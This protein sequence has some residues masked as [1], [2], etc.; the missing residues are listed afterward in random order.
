MPTVRQK[1]ADRSRS[2]AVKRAWPIQTGGRAPIVRQSRA[3]PAIG[4]ARPVDATHRRGRGRDILDLVREP[5]F[6]VLRK[7][8][9]HTTPWTTS[10][11]VAPRPRAGGTGR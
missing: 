3:V 4:P 11:A 8:H 6:A 5:P 7:P 9:P 2:L 1:S 10:F